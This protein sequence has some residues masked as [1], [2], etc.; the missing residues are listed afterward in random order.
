M[1]RSVDLSW[2]R[3]FV[4]G[5][6]HA[7]FQWLRHNH[8]VWWHEA[9]SH[10]PDGIGFWVVS[11][12]ADAVRIMKDPATFSS[13][14]GGTAIGDNA[15]AGLSLHQSDDPHHRRLRDLVSR[16]F[17]PRTMGAL[18]PDL[19]ER[20]RR[21]LDGVPRGETF[22]FV[23]TVAQEL[24]LQAICSILGVPQDDRKK[25]ARIVND[26]VEAD[27]GEGLSADSMRLLGA[28]GS[29]LIGQKRKNPGDDILSI[30]VHAGG[31]DG[32][33]R[34]TD[35]ELK[36]F[37]NLLFPAGAETTR[38]AI[39]G[40][41]HAL[42]ERPDQWSRLRA[43]PEV[44]RSAVEEIVRWT[45]PSCYKRRT[46]TRDVDVAGTRIEEGQKVTYWEMSANRDEAVFENP[47]E[48][49]IARD[50][51]PHVGFGI[52]THFCLGANLAR[53]EIRIMFEE[54]L[55]RFESFELAGEIAW[56]RNNRLFGLTKLPVVA[57]PR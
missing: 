16:G 42:I 3:S 51:N 14:A 10:T 21:I 57:H 2:G 40:G 30:I 6:P 35:R 54:L 24:P 44:M 8:P 13:G 11:R 46:T 18:E 36:A 56:P 38:S 23:S 4:D 15:G 45:T 49:D 50:P 53:L 5:Y 29:D 33:P 19:R 9:T 31:D 25:L 52:G 26:A 41:L 1:T 20:T 22:N 28:Y 43:D 17:T 37:F 34:L 32:T 55:D 12:Y 39:A 47:F 7:F 27:T 48:F